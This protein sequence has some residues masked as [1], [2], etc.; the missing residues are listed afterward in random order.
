MKRLLTTCLILF[1]LLPLTG[2]QAKNK[3]NYT[4]STKESTVLQSIPDRDITVQAAAETHAAIDGESP[5]T[6]LPWTG[7]YLPVLVQIGNTTTT[8]QVN[9]R[10]VKASGIGKSTPWGIQYADILY[11]ESMIAN[12]GGTRLTA[13]FSDCFASGQPESGVGPVRSC[14]I[15]ALL[16]REEWQSGLIYWGGFLGTFSWKD[17]QTPQFLSDYNVPETGALLNLMSNQYRDMRYRVQKKKAPG[18]MNVDLLRM[19]DTI[20]DSFVTTAHPFLFTDGTED[21]S[22]YE[23]ADT[24]N[25]DWGYKYNISHFMYDESQNAYIRFC[26]AGIKPAKWATFMAYTSP[27]ATEEESKVPLVFSNVIIQRVTYA[28]EATT[29]YRVMVQ[30]VGRGNADIFI[31]GRYIP[32]Y[33]VRTS[34]EDPTVFYDDQGNELVLNRGKTFIAHFPVDGLCAFTATE[35]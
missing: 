15:G 9:G 20:P 17:T 23:A 26:G 33:W 3:I 10:D 28:D 19:R 7:E 24:I 13:L 1:L 27:E 4:L 6:G 22:A 14:R 16:L 34:I 31:G 18:N 35:T 21:R 25:L 30:S 11:E 8:T 29:Q 5:T 32:G 12:S 2:A